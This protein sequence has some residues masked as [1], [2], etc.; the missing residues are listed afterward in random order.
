MEYLCWHEQTSTHCPT[1][2][3]NWLVLGYVK[4]YDIHHIWNPDPLPFFDIPC[5]SLYIH[6][7][8]DARR[9]IQCVSLFLH[10]TIYHISGWFSNNIHAYLSHDTTSWSGVEIEKTVCSFWICVCSVH[11][12]IYLYI[13]C[14]SWYISCFHIA[15]DKSVISC[16]RAVCWCLIM[17]AYILHAQHSLSCSQ[18]WKKHVCRK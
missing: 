18:K 16:C 5:V 17:P 9:D 4:T 8:G 13:P 1:A 10:T 15:K 12:C 3:N 7:W 14:I 2:R 11:T 6:V